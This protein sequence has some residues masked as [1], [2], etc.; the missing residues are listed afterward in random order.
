M[1]EVLWVPRLEIISVGYVYR[2]TGKEMSKERNILHDANHCV[3]WCHEPK[4]DG[5]SRKWVGRRRGE[6]IIR[7]SG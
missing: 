7:Q 6:D 3:S 5:L 4:I 2:H 1:I